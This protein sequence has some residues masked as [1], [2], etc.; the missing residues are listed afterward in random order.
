[1]V[2]HVPGAEPGTFVSTAKTDGATSTQIASTLNA[3]T[4]IE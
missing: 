1:M 2:A 3:K 4:N